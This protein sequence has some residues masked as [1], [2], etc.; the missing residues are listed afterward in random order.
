MS[1]SSPSRR[2]NTRID[3]VTIIHCVKTLQHKVPRN[4]EEEATSS[5]GVSVSGQDS[6]RSS[7]ELRKRRAS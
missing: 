4:T 7:F 1:S 3:N 5:V 6:R 2:G